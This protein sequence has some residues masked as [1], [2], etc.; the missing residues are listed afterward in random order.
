MLQC[1]QKVTEPPL[2]P[3]AGRRGAVGSGQVRPALQGLFILEITLEDALHAS[4][5]AWRRAHVSVG[6]VKTSRSVQ[7]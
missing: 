2:P 4:P 7:R 6:P 5:G 1:L 3:G